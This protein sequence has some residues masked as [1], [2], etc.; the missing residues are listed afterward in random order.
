MLVQLNISNFAII[1]HLEIHFHRG[2]NIIS[3]ETGAGKS[4]IINAMN[5]LLGSRASADLIRTGSK[6]ARVEG[7]FRIPLDHGIA[8]LLQGLDIPFDG[9]LVIKRS[10][11]REGR[12]RI[13]IN[14][15]MVT[16][17]TLSRLGGLLIS[18]SGQHAHQMLLRPENHLYVLDSYAGLE[19][20][21]Q[22]LEDQIRQ[23]QHIR[24]QISA[25]D[26]E[27]NRLK[28]Q[29]ELAKFQIQEIEAA[30]IS[31]EEDKELMEE[32]RRLEHGEELLRVVAEGY[33]ALYEDENA[34][35][36]MVSRCL[37]Q[38]EKALEIDPRLKV[39]FEAL[40][41]SL[42][43]IEDTAFFLRDFRDQIEL[44]PGRLD[45]VV[46]R[47]HLLNELKRKYGSTLVEVLSFKE[48][49]GS[50]VE[51]MAVK[52]AQ[53]EEL[54]EKASFIEKE[55]VD[56]AS[57]LSQKR[58]SARRRLEKA[59][60]NEL[61][62]L[63]MKGTRFEVKFSSPTSPTIEHIG[64]TG[65]D[66][67]QFMICPNVGET[68][69]PLAKIASGG[70]LSRIML[71]LKSILARKA[72][73]ETVIFDE[74]DAGISGATAE[75]VGEKLLNLSRYHQILCITHLPQIAS[76]GKT[77]FLVRKRVVG[78]RTEAII[79]KL[80]HHERVEEIARLLG[81]KKITQKALSHAKEM[82]D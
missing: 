77:H 60:E 78:S 8:D 26:Q 28:E 64:P 59:I 40:E 29:Q 61:Q 3:G 81:G 66:D 41:E 22:A 43:K 47:L 9:E 39:G 34:A 69:R 38:L 1:K 58:R 52:E 72:S 10:I 42:A 67:V 20:E 53:L 65:F 16:L 23:Y 4:I 32:K 70:E 25:L 62:E 48:K 6:E 13:L 33:K 79:N 18:I 54:K 46:E 50:V 55:I 2:L 27:L 17:A 7:L 45:E 35:F 63:H 57:I 68:L 24:D 80:D 37:T 73:V 12:N 76:K 75:V 31:P 51:D 14:D 74:V 82:L 19:N 5:L 36:S 21:R 15:S 56:K 49:L 44:D 11:N 71:A 30:Q